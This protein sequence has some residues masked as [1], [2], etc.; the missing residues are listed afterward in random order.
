[1]CFKQTQKINIKL[2]KLTLLIISI[3][4]VIGSVTYFVTNKY[5]CSNASCFT[6]VGI[7]KFKKVEEYQSTATTHSSLFARDN[8]LL[9]VSTEFGVNKET[10]DKLLKS[11]TTQVMAVYTDA[12]SPYPGELSDKISCDKQFEPQFSTIDS[13]GITISTFRG[14]YNDRLSFGVCN[15]NQISFQG[16]L[17]FF[18]CP[19][20]EQFHTLEYA[21]PFTETPNQNFEELKKVLKTVRC[22]R[23]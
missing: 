19:K 14:F 15:K 4:I 9:R 11:K 20:Y 1:M 3:L 21:L 23:N 7:E 17:S 13:N 8:I 2:N 10:A 6:F 18:Y 16:N 22:G 5:N 12:V